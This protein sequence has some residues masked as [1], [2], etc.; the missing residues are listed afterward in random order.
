MDVSSLVEAINYDLKRN[1]SYDRYPIRFLYLKY[2]SGI[3]DVI[4]QLKKELGGIDTFDIKEILPHEDGWITPDQLRKA[5]E[6]LDLS[7]SF[8]V[9]GFSE[10]ARFLGEKDF[11]SLLLTFLELENSNKNQKRRIY[12]PCFALYSQIKK[13]IKSYHRRMDAYNPFLNEADVEDLPKIYFLDENL[14]IDCSS[15]EIRSSAEWFGMWRNADIDT[16][17]PIFCL[18]KTLRYFYEKASPDNVYNIQ[19]LKSYQDILHYIYAIDQLHAYKKDAEG[20]YSQLIVRIKKYT[21]K[22]L[23]EIILSELNVQ[24]IDIDDMYTLWKRSNTFKRWLI[25]NYLLNKLPEN[26]YLYKVMY[27]LEDLSDKEFVETI[28]KSIFEYADRSFIEQ[29]KQILK[30]IKDLEK[31]IDFTSRLINYYNKYMAEIIRKK[32]VV[33][34]EEIDFKEEY[35]ILW[36]NRSILVEAFETEMIPYLT[37]Y[38]CYERQLIIWLYRWKLMKETQIKNIYPALWN[39]ISG[40]DH[41]ME[42]DGHLENFDKYFKTYRDVR[43]GQKADT[44]YN[45]ALEEWNKDENTFYSWYSKNE[46]EYPEVYLR[47]KSFHSTVYVLDG[48]GAEF[49]GYILTLLQDRGYHVNS[50]AYAKCHLPSITS[51]SKKYYPEEYKWLSDYD[52][53][54]V[55]GEGYYHVCSIEKSLS[56]IESLIDKIISKEDESCFAITA[57][58]GA[59]VGHKLH[60]KDKKYKFEQSEHDGRCYYNKEKANIDK[61]NDYLIYDDETGGQWVIALNQQSLYKNSKYVVH[62]G[63]TLEEVLVPVI[64]AQKGRQIS[65]H[66]NITAINLEVSGLQRK[67]EFNIRP[68]PKDIKVFFKAK[69]GTDKELIYHKDTDSWIGELERGI[70]QDME[71]IIDKQT[72]PFRTIPPTKMGGD[73][74][75]DD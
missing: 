51:V 48:V 36:K 38:S 28:Y 72:F 8:I 5:M 58:H 34:L 55:H 33:T 60:K 56:V 30:T 21:G 62:G 54:V 12:F 29:R 35:E 31:N 53:Q 49:I 50:A 10:Y 15:N 25:Q 45:T 57:D 16:R 47:N 17:D 61:S 73:D 24:N 64:I 67:V 18:S 9:I 3:S 26:N 2:E 65:K 59:T 44:D 69:D 66:Y 4:I 52:K 27:L 11:C 37:C 22:P 20:F 75:F 43:L 23:E 1:G 41:D 39:Y 63:A 14:G 32:I 68:V 70:E 46:V 42:F 71:V 6:E 40:V 19:L 7:K 74:L 13:A